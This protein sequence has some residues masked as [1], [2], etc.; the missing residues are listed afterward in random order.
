VPTLGQSQDPS[1]VFAKW[2][3]QIAANVRNVAPQ[4]TPQNFSVTN[5]PGTLTL[6][7]GQV[8][9]SSG[10]DGYEILKS[11]SGNFK[12]DL[13]VIPIGHVNQTSY[14]DA[15][16]GSTK[17]SYRIRTTSGTP[18]TPQSA[19][20]PESGV[21]AHTSLATT[22]TATG[23]TVRDQVTTDKSRS[24]ARLG[25]YGIFKPATNS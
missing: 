6:K 10:A 5:S 23:V 4:A 14:T 2:Q 22:S 25:N 15:V 1:V 16:G 8:L 20:G 9:N 11:V 17:C 19:R 18:Q 12:T 13:Q 24:L 3:S 7:W 21:V